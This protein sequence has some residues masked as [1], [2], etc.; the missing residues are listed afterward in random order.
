M[1]TVTILDTGAPNPDP[2]GPA[3]PNPDPDT[4]TEI[5]SQI[6]SA[7]ASRISGDPAPVVICGPG[8]SRPLQR[9]LVAHGLD[10]PVLAYPEIP[11]TVNMTG[12]AVIG[13][14]AAAP[15][16]EVGP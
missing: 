1:V 5:V 15:M 7:V 16:L 9:F 11:S 10:L 4:G 12:I 14:P 6:Q 2:V 8:L 3:P 13:T